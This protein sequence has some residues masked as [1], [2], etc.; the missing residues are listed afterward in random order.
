MIEAYLSFVLGAI[1]SLILVL[2]WGVV[3]LWREY[4]NLKQD[5]QQLTKQIK[6]THDDLAGLCSAAI[7]VDSRMAATENRVEY[8][9]DHLSTNQASLSQPDNEE[10]FDELDEAPQ[11]YGLAIEKI[12][13]GANLEELVKACALT[14][15]EAVLLMRLHGKERR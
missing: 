9:V 7:A 4:K 14:R 6:R 1:G 3:W 11:G 10:T 13:Q 12:R 2:G 15:D 5:H 8:L